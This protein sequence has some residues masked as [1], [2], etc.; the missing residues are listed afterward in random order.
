MGPVL[1]FGISNEF[2]LTSYLHLRI[3]VPPLVPLGSLVPSDWTPTS[4]PRLGLGPGNDGDP[5]NSDRDSDSRNQKGVTPGGKTKD[6]CIDLCH[7]EACT[8][9]VL[10]GS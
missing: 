3:P 9:E 7:Q 5:E 1:V 2:V 8:R 6:A 4:L 10:G